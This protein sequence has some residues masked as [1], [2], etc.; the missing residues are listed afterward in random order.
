MG[1]YSQTNVKTVV[2]DMDRTENLVARIEGG[3]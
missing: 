2:Y 3:T 1:K